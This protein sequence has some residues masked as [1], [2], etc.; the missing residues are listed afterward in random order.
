MVNNKMISSSAQQYIF[1]N[2]AWI[3]LIEYLNQENTHMKNRLSEIIEQ[4]P[5]RESLA[6]AEQFQNQFL[7]KD[8]LYD[9]MIHALMGQAVKWKELK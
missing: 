4:I 3:R 8:D 7:T 6:V 2:S 9:H 1:E 5:D